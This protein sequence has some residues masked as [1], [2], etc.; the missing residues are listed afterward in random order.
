M[1]FPIPVSSSQMLD[2]V[3]LVSAHEVG[4]ALGLVDTTYL[5]GVGDMHNPGAEDQTKTMNA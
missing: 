5:G 2:A 1:N 3:C 4:H